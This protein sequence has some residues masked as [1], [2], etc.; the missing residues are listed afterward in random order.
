M[1]SYTILPHSLS[2]LA[3]K[4]SAPDCWH[5]GN[6]YGHGHRWLQE[7]GPHAWNSEADQELIKRDG[8][9][10]IHKIHLP[11]C[12][13]IMAH[14]INGL[15]QWCWSKGLGCPSAYFKKMCLINNLLPKITLDKLQTVQ[16]Y[17]V[18]LPEWQKKLEID[19]QNIRAAITFCLQLLSFII[20]IKFIRLIF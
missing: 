9:R 8:C 2:L 3:C 16:F 7:R 10:K 12:G 19:S 6:N 13:K 15:I 17:K 20:N 18:T 11:W 14:W 4:M 1:C 5:C